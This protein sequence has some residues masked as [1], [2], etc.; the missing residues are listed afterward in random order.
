MKNVLS[1]IKG[2]PKYMPNWM[3][4]LKGGT[5]A[6]GILSPLVLNLSKSDGQL[7]QL[8]LAD[9][10]A[11]I[12]VE[13]REI[14]DR[15]NWLCEK[16]IVSPKEFRNSYPAILGD[17]Y[18]PQWSIYSCIMLNAALSN[19][20]RIW[21][22]CRD[23][24]LVKM[25][26]LIDLLLSD[27]LKDYDA[28]EWGEDPLTSLKGTKSHMTYLSILAWSLSNYHFAGGD[29]RY[30]KL[31]C[32]ICEALN[33]RMLRHKDL[34]LLSF[35]NK[36]VFFPDMLVTILA[37]HNYTLLFD[38]RYENTIARWFELCK[39]NWMNRRTGLIVAMLY[40]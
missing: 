9:S 3:Q 25:E 26:K 1:F 37:L 30:D 2:S 15:A 31:F 40:G 10:V 17:Y 12:D 6:M 13:K 8:P 23:K 34:N 39:E 29:N 32:D 33:R 24:C 28:R 19:I 4:M 35:P 36:P 38:D 7:T 14:L 5:K 22:D 16:I 20:A 27:E 11:Y 21:P 18:G